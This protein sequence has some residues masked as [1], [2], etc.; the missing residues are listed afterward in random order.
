MHPSY[1]RHVRMLILTFRLM[2]VQRRTSVNEYVPITNIMF[3][4]Q[5]RKIVY[6]SDL[7]KCANMLAKNMH[8]T[9][10]ALRL[11]HC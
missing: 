5:D 4:N 7:L 11:N 6:N 10:F 2:S 1:V 8:S 9:M 3:N